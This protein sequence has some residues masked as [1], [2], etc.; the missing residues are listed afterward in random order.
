MHKSWGKSKGTIFT[1]TYMQVY[2]P[3]NTYRGI[4]ISAQG[5]GS[6]PLLYKPIHIGIQ[7]M[8]NGE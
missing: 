6:D 7:N 2:T 3:Q 8:E 4:T 1:Y 5:N